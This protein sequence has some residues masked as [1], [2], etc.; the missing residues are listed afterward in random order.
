M[1]DPSAYVALDLLDDSGKPF[2]PRRRILV[3]TTTPWTLVSNV[4]LAVNPALEY[5]ELK[6]ENRRLPKK[7]A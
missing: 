3:W 1:K 4:A 7:G 5:V 2:S 6:K